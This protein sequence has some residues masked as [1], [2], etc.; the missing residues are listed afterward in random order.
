MSNTNKE[1]AEL[2]N[3]VDAHGKARWATGYDEGCG[4]H[5][6][7]RKHDKKAIE[8]RDDLESALREAIAQPEQPVQPKETK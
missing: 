6:D 5:K 8:H 4:N 2:M 1:L 7:G 3:L